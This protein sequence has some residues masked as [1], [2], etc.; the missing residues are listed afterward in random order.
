MEMRGRR[1]YPGP[2]GAGSTGGRGGGA[3]STAYNYEVFDFA[4]E[5]G[6]FE[7]WLQ[8]GPGI[9]QEAPDFEL[10][11]LEGEA[12]RL[13]ALRDR[14]VVLEFGS[15]TCPIFS[16]RVPAMER[17]A[18]DHPEAAFLVIYVR[19][20]HPGEIQG[21][22]RS[23]VEKW[24][25]ARRLVTAEVL[26]RRVLV[27]SLDGAVHRAYGGAWNPVYVIAPSDGRVVMRQ[28]W[29]HPAL[30]GAVLDDLVAGTV[31]KVPESIEML[32][33][34]GC[35]PMGLRL[36]ERG[37]ARALRDFYRSAPRPVSEALRSSAS[38]AVRE[39]ILGFE[40]DRECRC[41]PRTRP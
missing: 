7:R 5:P 29:N 3:V 26:A 25:A 19:E 16:D 24:S 33:E 40:D 6:E 36:L 14:P 21:P 32:R 1:R 2:G 18:Q 9:G 27:D 30:V 37:G 15:Y 35:R 41:R 28:A 4:L 38:E 39:A 12:L 20:A 34:A 8:A 31:S 23:L 13:S 11:D 22:H 17:L 10:L